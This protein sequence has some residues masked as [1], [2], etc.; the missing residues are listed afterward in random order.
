MRGNCNIC[1]LR[2][3]SMDLITQKQTWCLLFEREV[4]NKGAGC[5]NWRPDC[6][7]SK[8]EKIQIAS[9]IK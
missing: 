4:E 7:L 8:N 3:D 5:D 9:E 1:G 2:D 6:N